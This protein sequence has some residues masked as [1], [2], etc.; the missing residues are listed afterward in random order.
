MRGTSD[1]NGSSS[2]GYD[3]KVKFLDNETLR[4]TYEDHQ[5]TVWL[6]DLYVNTKDADAETLANMILKKAA[7]IRA[8]MTDEKEQASA[9]FNADVLRRKENNS[10][11]RRSFKTQ[12]DIVP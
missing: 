7:G 11:K 2:I 3:H 4:I 8:S 9:D 10:E 5:N 12:H 1:T 6:V